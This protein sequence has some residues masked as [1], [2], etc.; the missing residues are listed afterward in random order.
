MFEISLDGLEKMVTHLMTKNWDKVLS[1]TLAHYIDKEKA[2]SY[3]FRLEL[4]GV[5]RKQWVVEFPRPL[6]LGICTTYWI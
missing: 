2:F 4:E 1:E 5:L 6:R 3:D